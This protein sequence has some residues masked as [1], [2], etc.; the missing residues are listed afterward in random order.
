M[1]ICYFPSY[2]K[3]M[4]YDGRIMDVFEIILTKPQKILCD[5]FSKDWS[6]Q[7]HHFLTVVIRLY[8]NMYVTVAKKA[9]E[10]LQMSDTFK[11]I[12]PDAISCRMKISR[13]FSFLRFIEGSDSCLSVATVKIVLIWLI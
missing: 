2:L 5:H 10:K 8:E 9:R 1:L 3:L 6:F 13:L 11:A 4:L 12:E 7:G